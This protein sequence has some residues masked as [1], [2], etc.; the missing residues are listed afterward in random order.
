LD[1]EIFGKLALHIQVVAAKISNYLVGEWWSYEGYCEMWWHDVDDDD[2]SK[3][4]MMKLH[5]Y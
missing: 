2:D 5:Q 3:L 4:E 1:C